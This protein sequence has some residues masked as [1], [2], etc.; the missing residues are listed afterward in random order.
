VVLILMVTGADQV[1]TDRKE[2][3][4]TE[5]IKRWRVD[6]TL[7]EKE[8]LPRRNVGA[9]LT[10]RLMSDTWHSSARPCTWSLVRQIWS[11]LDEAN[12]KAEKRR[13]DERKRVGRTSFSSRWL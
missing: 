9:H 11:C 1:P 7:E 13:T 12:A 4:V 5:T 6:S 10:Y 2:N 8:I 3:R